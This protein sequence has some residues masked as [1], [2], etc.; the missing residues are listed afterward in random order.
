MK[1]FFLSV[2]LIALFTILISCNNNSTE[3]ELQQ[4]RRDYV[5]TRD[6]LR[7]D[8]FG[9]QSL[10]S[11]WGSSPNDV[12][13]VGDAATYVNKIWHY[14]GTKWKNYLLD[15]YAEPISVH[16]ISSSEIWMV[17]TESDVWKYDGI[18]WSKFTT[19]V[20]D[21]YKRILFEDI[22]GYRNN[23]Y[24]VGIAEKQDGDYTG[25]I[26]HYNGSKW[27][28]LNTYKIKEYFVRVKFLE[29]GDILI[30]SQNYLEPHE[31]SRLYKYK[32]GSLTLL[33]KSNLG[34]FCEILNNGIY[35]STDK[36][37]YEYKDGSLVETI[38][39]TD[40]KYIG[41]LWG[42]TISDFFCTN[43]GWNLGHYNGT[44]LVNIYQAEGF[45]NDIQLFDKDV[46]VICHVLG[47]VYYA[48]HG[49][50]N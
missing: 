18:K 37:I 8:Q 16:G 4:G 47:S 9:F 35:I 3:P 36:K 24:A 34:I 10:T 21:G 40:T 44:D 23:L 17:T 15:Q 25:V 11:I 29:R 5:W 49:K 12:W 22:Y 1:H 19:I 32:D 28:V 38:N 45:I 2:L 33:R 50:L 6:T 14:D 46:F 41:G 48:L 7:A 43:D 26:V 13:I 42:H 39:L 27:E 20:P 31:P 30:Y